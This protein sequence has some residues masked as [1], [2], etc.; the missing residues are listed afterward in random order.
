MTEEDQ[1]D[2]R[3]IA[4][5]VVEAL[6]EDIRACLR[7][8]KENHVAADVTAKEIADLNLQIEAVEKGK[9]FAAPQKSRTRTSS[10][11]GTF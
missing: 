8:W 3:S 9:A 5:E 6:K 7:R 2:Y 4:D 11:G 1:R 10:V